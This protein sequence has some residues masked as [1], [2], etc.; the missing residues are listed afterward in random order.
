MHQAKILNEKTGWE[1]V[2][3]GC[4]FVLG[5]TLYHRGPIEV[6]WYLYCTIFS[7]LKRVTSSEVVGK[8]EAWATVFAVDTCGNGSYNMGNKSR[9]LHMWGRSSTRKLCPW[10]LH[11]GLYSVIR[12]PLD[13]KMNSVSLP[14]ASTGSAT[15]SSEVH[16]PALPAFLSKEGWLTQTGFWGVLSLWKALQD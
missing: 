11:F 14:K 15:S 9:A 6:C 13:W 16:P 4:C 12:G 5:V 8:Q 1:K 7:L 2:H 3:C 10:P